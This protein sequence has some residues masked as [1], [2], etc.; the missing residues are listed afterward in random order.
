MRE[1]GRGRERERER[2]R[3][4]ERIDRQVRLKR[5]VG[6]GSSVMV[7]SPA[8]SMVNHTTTADVQMCKGCKFL[9]LTLTVHASTY[10]V[11]TTCS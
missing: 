8:A 7:V 2:G 3:G 6:C 11:Y 10:Q 1:R 4:R 5:E 9:T